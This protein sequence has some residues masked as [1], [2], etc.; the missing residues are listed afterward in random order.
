MKKKEEDETGM[1]KRED[2]DDTST[3]AVD[4]AEVESNGQGDAGT[5]SSPWSIESETVLFNSLCKFKPVGIH[6]HFRMISLSASL[7]YYFSESPKDAPVFSHQDVW[8]KLGTLYDLD[9]LDEL[10]YV[11]D[12]QDSDMDEDEDDEAAIE[13]IA[14]RSQMK[15]F[16]LPFR[17]YGFLQIEQATAVASEQSSPAMSREQSVLEDGPTAGDEKKGLADDDDESSDLDELDDEEMKLAETKIKV[18]GEQQEREENGGEEEHDT[19]EG[20]AEPEEAEKSEEEGEGEESGESESESGS[21]SQSD[22][23]AQTGRQRRTRA[24]TAAAVRGRGTSK[25]KTVRDKKSSPST[26]ASSAPRRSTR[27]KATTEPED[28]ATEREET[29]TPKKSSGGVK[30]PAPRRSTRRKK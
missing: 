10:E 30:K 23:D 13:G 14:K 9:G 22:S 11:A 3:Q 19:M 2:T 27:R 8:D 17:D 24:A 5:D 26:R 15:E 12:N 21:E 4:G 29:P 20:S 7:N 1:V 6:K 16:V 18:E 28:T 25:G